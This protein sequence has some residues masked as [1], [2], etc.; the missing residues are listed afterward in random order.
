MSP[1]YGKDCYGD[2]RLGDVIPDS[3]LYGVVMQGV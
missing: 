1:D 3:P 2:V